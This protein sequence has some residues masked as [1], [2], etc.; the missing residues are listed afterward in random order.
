[1]LTD[2]QELN[3][4]ETHLLYIGDKFGSEILIR[5]TWLP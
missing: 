3:V 5:K 4:G 1:M 2:W